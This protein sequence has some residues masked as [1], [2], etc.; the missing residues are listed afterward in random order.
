[1]SGLGIDC[2]RSKLGEVGSSPCCSF[3]ISGTWGYDSGF[4]ET[5]LLATKGENYMLDPDD[6]A[7]DV[8]SMDSRLEA[9]VK[10][11]RK[12]NIQTLE[13]RESMERLSRD[14]VF[15]KTVL[16]ETKYTN[17]HIKFD[18]RELIAPIEAILA[19]LKTIRLLIAVAGLL[20]VTLL[21]SSYF[22]E[23]SSWFLSLAG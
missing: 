10:E 12:A 5:E 1:M 2:F 17:E 14:N 7:K 21:V 4:D 11:L 20:A 9:M 22:S 13:V 3:V 18:L 15:I 16:E 6:F 8:K 19:C 23:I